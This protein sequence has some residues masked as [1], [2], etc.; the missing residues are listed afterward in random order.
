[1]D[2]KEQV[3][4]VL[5][6]VAQ[7]EREAIK[8]RQAE[9]IAA[10]HARGVKFGRP[11]TSLPANFDETVERWK[12]GEIGSG[13]KAAEICGMASSTFRGYVKDY[14]E[15]D[16]Y[17]ARVKKCRVENIAAGRQRKKA[18]EAHF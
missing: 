8:K 6:Y 2:L 10:A 1:M 9:G 12:K 3:T 17:K 16:E 4:S 13:R 18:R 15:S 5:A 7:M 14:L 11:R